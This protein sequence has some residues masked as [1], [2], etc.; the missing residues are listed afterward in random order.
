MSTEQRTNR[1][2]LRADAKSSILA[3]IV[4]AL[5]PEVAL[6]VEPAARPSNDMPTA[7]AAASSP[8]PDPAVMRLADLDGQWRLLESE[9]DLRARMLAIDVALEPLTW[10]VRKMAGGVLRSTTAPRSTLLFVWDGERLHERVP[11][12]QR[13]ETRLIAPGAAEFT[14]V[15]HR[16]DSFSGV[17]DWTSEGLRFRWRQHQAYGANLYRM[18]PDKR[19]LT[20]DHSIQVTALDGLRPIVYRS[21]FA[22]DALPAVS[23][24]GDATD[25]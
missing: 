7:V 21:R 22:K 3:L 11:G 16:G 15:D 14:A 18:D 8:K 24:A 10:V 4:I 25:R 9:S 1:T 19:N 13:V 23:T 2:R 20:I 5:A 6:A 12:K 17:W